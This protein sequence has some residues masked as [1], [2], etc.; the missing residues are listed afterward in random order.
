[1]NWWGTRLVE[2]L[3]VALATIAMIA[4]TAQASTYVVMI[5]L[6]SPIY[7]ELDTLD[8]LGYL[9]T[10]FSE[11]RPFS[12]IEAARLTLEAE[13]NMKLDDQYEPL[14]VQLTK[15][16]DLQLSEEIGWLRSNAE[17]DQPNIIHPLQ[18]ADAQYIYSV[19]SRRHWITIPPGQINAQ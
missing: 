13:R 9:D 8:G 15:T 4:G 16:L 1:M 3:S 6:D 7:S 10:Y 19:G 17:D 18:S 5:P 12:R 11:I 2:A 14:A